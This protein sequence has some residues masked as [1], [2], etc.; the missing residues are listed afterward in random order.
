MHYPG[1]ESVSVSAPDKRTVVTIEGIDV[2]VRRSGKTLPGI[3]GEAILPL[4]ELAWSPDSKAFF[5][6]WSEGG[7]V[8]QWL[9]YVYLIEEEKVRRVNVVKDVE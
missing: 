4:A 1:S 8:G 5:I 9:T 2:L 6:T 7:S 3:E